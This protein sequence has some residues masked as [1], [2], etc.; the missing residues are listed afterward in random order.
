[1]NEIIEF[2]IHFDVPNHY[3]KIDDFVSFS[4][5]L[6]KIIADFSKEIFDN[7]IIVDVYILP[8]E[9]GS[10]LGR[11]GIRVAK[12]SVSIGFI[13]MAM[14]TDISKSFI[15][16]LTGH[17]PSYYS[18]MAGSK[19]RSAAMLLADLSRGFL[20][21]DAN[22]EEL[23]SVEFVK[24]SNAY[25]SKDDFYGKCLSNDEISGIGFTCD[26]E[27]PIRKSAFAGKISNIVDGD[28]ELEP[29]YEIHQLRVVSSVN[30][31]DSKAQWQLQD[32][33]TR[34]FLKAHL[35]DDDFRQNFFNGKYPLKIHETDDVIIAM[36]EYRKASV[37]GSIKIIERNII[38]IYKFN[39]IVFD[40][41]PSYLT[42]S[43]VSRV[44]SGVS[45][46]QLSFLDSLIKD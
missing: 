44:K 9:P 38:K 16:G 8:A 37:E 43:S 39:N 1:M 21:K 3:L 17:K 4:I 2:P 22:A 20:E 31:I 29:E 41:V 24:F 13:F 33:Q 36:I 28:L 40:D 32:T 35:K 25:S 7:N 18:E 23:K 5:D 30:T 42:I 6:K 10:L 34:R 27:F 11:W 14:D 19:T 45:E 46:R 15:L 12:T 26:D